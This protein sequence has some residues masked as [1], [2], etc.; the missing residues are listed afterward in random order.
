MLDSQKQPMLDNN[1]HTEFYLLLHKSAI[2]NHRTAVRIAD[3]LVRPRNHRPVF[4]S[5]EVQE[6]EEEK[7]E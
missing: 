2:P 1:P 5:E 4:L 6:A 7:A 3:E